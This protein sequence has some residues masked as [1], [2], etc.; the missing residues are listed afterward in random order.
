GSRALFPTT[1][2]SGATR[3]CHT[4]GPHLRASA[5][6][7]RCPMRDPASATDGDLLRRCQT[8][9][10]RA[11]DALLRRYER[12]IYSIPLRCGLNEEDAADVF[13]FI[14]IQL[15]NNLERVRDEEHLTAWIITL[16]KR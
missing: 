14:C 10:E 16:A 2:A 3:V 15:L 11:W 7:E 1:P 6:P 12:L 4:S 8:G 9:E 5:Y 13:Q